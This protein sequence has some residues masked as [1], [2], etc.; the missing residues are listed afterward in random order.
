M[1]RP[2]DTALGTARSV[3]LD[4]PA[5]LDPAL[6]GNK[7]SGLAHLRADGFDVPDAVVLTIGWAATWQPD[8]SPPDILVQL[9]A[10]AVGQLGPRL[11]VRSSATWE[12]GATSA[13]AGASETVLDV[14]GVD[15]TLDAV[16]RCLDGTAAAAVARRVEGDIAVIIQTLVDADFA[17]VA[18]SADPITGERDVVRLAATA[19]LGEALVQGD[20]VGSDVA[21]RDDHIEGDL[22]G[23]PAHLAIAIADAA[24]RV[25]A[26]RGA[27]QDVEWAV[28]DGRVLL[29]QTRPITVL[30]VQPELPEGNNWQKD[31]AHYPEPMTPFGWSLLHECSDQIRSVFD[32]RGLLVRGLEERF[33]GG[34]VYGRVL[35]TFGSPDG[36]G[37]PPPAFVMGVAA[38]LVPELRRRTAIAK[39]ALATNQAETWA[40]NWWR[41]DRDEMVARAAALDEVDLVALDD[42][43][44]AAAL[45]DRL[46][47]LRQGMTIHFQ[48]MIP[49]FTAMHALHGLVADQLGWEDGRT[50][51][52]LAG[53]SP[54]TRAPAEAMGALQERLGATPGARD[55]LD[56]APATPVETLRAV[57]ADLGAAVEAW[58][59]EHGWA[60]VNY[61]GGVPVLAE[62][63]LVVSRLLTHPPQ[64]PAFDRADAV[65]AE[66]R[67]ALPGEQRAR[68]D[69]LLQRARDLYGVREDNTVV[70]G[71]R[72]TALLRRAMLEA[73]RRLADDGVVASADD[74]AYLFFGELRAALGG[75]QRDGLAELVTR[76]R[77]EEAYVRARPGPAYVGEQGTPPDISRLPAALRAVNEPILWG[78]AHEY[79]EPATRPDDASVLAAG[80]AASP[81]RAVGPARIIRGHDEMDRL[82]AGD[83]LVC[84]VTSPAWA[85]LFPLA[86]AVVADGGGVL[87]HAAIAA[88]EHGLPAVLGTGDAMATI[89]DG[90]QVE[91]DGS[92]GLVRAV[93]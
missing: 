88:R 73:G 7:A 71:D 25:E 52:M 51:A 47:L 33:V 18:F 85:P 37:K 26:A 59:G 8:T 75:G 83:V 45:D 58:L 53:H 1:T 36:A 89:S 42:E 38:R 10:D 16:R 86:V 40:D 87:S 6:V 55:A 22:A 19:G 65:A 20:V 56:A 41:N 5:A 90:Q 12:D 93:D 15:A 70:V 46:E 77:G 13:H 78:V 9:V 66:A 67:A 57:D 84:Q 91:V 48:L 62:R 60:P 76:R 92:T 80:V 82:R 49:L 27:P 43:E 61:D 4:D 14:Q 44:L 31:T 64:T 21:I 35:P 50:S 69:E 17:G 34:E 2:P 54:A 72:P 32:S 11:A 29:L 28:A 30:P 68:F 39:R 24:R 81:G 63:P 23:L 3:R 74:A 79:P